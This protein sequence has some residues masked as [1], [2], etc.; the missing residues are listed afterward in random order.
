MAQAMPSQ[1]APAAVRASHR[2]ASTLPPASPDGGTSWPRTTTPTVTRSSALIGR[3]AARCCSTRTADSSWVQSR[4]PMSSCIWVDGG[5]TRGNW[6]SR[7]PAATSPSP[8][9]MTKVSSATRRTRSGARSG[10]TTPSIPTMPTASMSSCTVAPRG[11]V[12]CSAMS[13]TTQGLRGHERARRHDP[14]C[15]RAGV[16]APRDERGAAGGG[17]EDAADDP[18]AQRRHRRRRRRRP[19]CVICPRPDPHQDEERGE[20]HDSRPAPVARVPPARTPAFRATPLRYSPSCCR[21]ASAASQSCRARRA[22][23]V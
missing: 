3:D 10:T 8:R 7:C 22:S 9:P 21:D 23:D 17:D 11:G 4:T 13:V 20:P 18:L 5:W 19:P 1:A 2:A 16:P 15:H 12:L 14:A 6:S